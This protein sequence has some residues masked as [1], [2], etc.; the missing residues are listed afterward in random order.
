MTERQFQRKLKKMQ[1]EGERYKQI[2]EVSDAYAEYFPE[3]KQRKT[4]NIMLVVSVTAVLGYVVAAF[5]IQLISGIEVSPTVT[6]LWFA[7]WTS[8]IWILSSIKKNK[9]KYSYDEINYNIEDGIGG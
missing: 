7:F 8:E 3:K 9:I 5:W 6:S 2:K 4:S 1:K